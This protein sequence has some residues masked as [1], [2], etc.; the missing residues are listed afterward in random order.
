MDPNELLARILAAQSGGVSGQAM[1]AAGAGVGRTDFSSLLDPSL[2]AGLGAFDPYQAAAGFDPYYERQ[3]RDVAQQYQT[4]QADILAGVVRPPELDADFGTVIPKY[5]DPKYANVAVPI[6][7]LFSL[8]LNGY[9]SSSAKIALDNLYGEFPELEQYDEQLRVDLDRYQKEREVVNEAAR[10]YTEAQISAQQR[11][12]ALPEPMMPDMDASRR[13]YYS[14]LGVP[15][16]AV[17]PDPRQT[18]QFGEGEMRALL[19]QSGGTREEQRLSRLQEADTRAMTVDPDELQRYAQNLRQ[20][21]TRQ[22]VSGPDDVGLIGRLTG[23]P[24]RPLQLAADA[25]AR[26][27]DRVSSILQQ[28]LLAQGRTPF[29]D[30]MRSLLQFAVTEAAPRP[31]ASSGSAPRLLN[32]ALTI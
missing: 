23:R 12:Q 1:G 19:G 24:E 22:P 25:A 13:E 31:R 10:R 32:P 3:L 2:L 28:N 20:G 5:A 29:E 27:R 7:G 15:G 11:L 21:G 30:S 17:L 9:D 16:M 18:Y 26:S 4:S 14:D 8:I 6:Q